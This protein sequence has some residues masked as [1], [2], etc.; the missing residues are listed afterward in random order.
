MLAKTYT[1]TTIGLQTIQVDVEVDGNQGLPILVLIGL[2]SKAINEARERI[3][4][5]LQNCNIRIRGKRTIVNLAPADIPKTGSGFDLAIAIGMLKMYGE[6]DLFTDD[7]MFFG[8]LSLD[9]SLKPIHGALPLV[10]TARSL[11]FKHVVIP[12]QNSD[13]VSIVSDISIHPISHLREFLMFAHGMQLLPF[14]RPKP[15]TATPPNFEIDFADVIGQTQA[16]RALTIAAAGGHN[17]LM[18]GSPGSGKTML[19]RAFT[20]ILPPLSEAEAIEVTHIYSVCGLTPHGL[21][22]QRPFRAPHHTISQMGLIGGGSSF[23]PGEISLAHRGVLFLDELLEFPRFLLESLR[24][25]LEDGNISISRATGSIVYPSTFSLVA[26]TNPCPCGYHF[27]RT[28]RCSCPAEMITRYQKRLSGPLLD[29][30]DLQLVVKD[31]ETEELILPPLSA[32]SS[33][34]R[35]QVLLARQRQAQRYHGISFHLNGELSTKH[36]KEFCHLTPAAQELLH[37]SAKKFSLSA[38]SYFKIVKIS[39]TI[40]DLEESSEIQEQHI[41]E[42]IQ[43]RFL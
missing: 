35:S 4:S 42:A 26:A 2:P 17:I 36:I 41:A 29:R 9:G 30:I 27:S 25:P 13:E 21:I 40:A 7:T 12:W 22:R 37:S 34:L 18:N 10:L 3:T 24:Q 33:D 15:F 28:K 16:K 39:Q 6:V 5:A 19:A 31:V 43:H 38:R 23:R 32:S 11:R 1:A 20:S 14:L 8:E